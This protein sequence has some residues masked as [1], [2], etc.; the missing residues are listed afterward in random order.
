MRHFTNT[1]PREA[2]FKHQ[3]QSKYCPELSQRALWSN[4]PHWNW[5]SL[6]SSGCFLMHKSHP[7]IV[8]VRVNPS[9]QQHCL[10]CNFSSM[11]HEALDLLDLLLELDCPLLA[12]SEYSW[13]ILL[14]QF[15]QCGSTHFPIEGPKPSRCELDLQGRLN[16]LCQVAPVWVPG[17]G[18]SQHYTTL[19]SGDLLFVT[20]AG[21]GNAVADRCIYTRT[22]E[23]KSD[24]PTDMSQCWQ[25]S[26][27]VHW[28]FSYIT[29][30]QT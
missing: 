2:R 11:S 30:W 25:R 22:Q 15:L 1:F 18:A 29:C 24:P 19:Q 27:L 26:P 17:P 9:C 21:G 6:H 7:N 23:T 5:G 28:S 20:T 12:S 13:L 8:S 4:W 16:G 14:I 3:Q 10:D